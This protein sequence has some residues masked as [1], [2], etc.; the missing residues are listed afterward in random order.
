MAAR[1][2]TAP[3]WADNN[4]QCICIFFK[5]ITF[6]LT[7]FSFFLSSRCVVLVKSSTQRPILAARRVA[8]SWTTSALSRTARLL[9]E[10]PAKVTSSPQRPTPAFVAQRYNWTLGNDI[11]I[12]FSWG[13]LL[14]SFDVFVCSAACHLHVRR[15]RQAGVFNLRF[16]DVC[17]FVCSSALTNNLKLV[18][19]TFAK[20]CP[21][22]A[23]VA[24]SWW[25]FTPYF[26]FQQTI[27]NSCVLVPG[28]RQM[29]G[30]RLC[31]DSLRARLRLSTPRRVGDSLVRCVSNEQ[32]LN[33]AIFF[34]QRMLQQMRPWLVW[35][36]VCVSVKIF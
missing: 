20:M 32:T 17:V 13:V 28:L 23:L 35:I 4:D 16:A 33:F 30:C 25:D 26:F 27:L 6:L 24:E 9:T 5:K 7:L 22:N 15:R 10:A 21:V 8:R 11:S 14:K 18:A 34:L 12:F 3:K 31:P 1:L 2:L 29:R 19:T 36:F